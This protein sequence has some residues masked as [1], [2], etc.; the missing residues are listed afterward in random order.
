MGIARLFCPYALL[1]LTAGCSTSPTM[2]R[3]DN[4]CEAAHSDGLGSSVCEIS[5]YQC[6]DGQTYTLDCQVGSSPQCACYIDGGLVG[7]SDAS[8][9]Q[10]FQA[11]P[12]H[13]SLLTVI[14]QTCGWCIGTTCPKR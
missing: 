9:C 7:E 3:P 6:D 1:A 14:N 5:W 10:A 4:I 13:P 2:Q 8:V 11:P 12:P